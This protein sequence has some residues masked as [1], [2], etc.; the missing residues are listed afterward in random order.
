MTNDVKN[1][2]HAICN[3]DSKLINAYAKVLCLNDTAAKDKN[4]CKSALAILDKKEEQSKITELPSDI[5]GLLH[6]ENLSETFIPERY[7]FR[8]YEKQILEKVINIHKII[9]ELN[10]KKIHFTN[11]LLLYGESGTGKTTLGKYIAYKLEL[12]FM[13]M[14]FSNVVSS[15]LGSTQKNIQKVF[16]FVNNKECVLMLDEI[17]AIGLSRGTEDVGEMSR[18]VISLMQNIDLLSNNVILVGATNRIDMIDKALLRRFTLKSEITRPKDTDERL[19]YLTTFLN[20]VGYEYNKE[21]LRKACEESKTQA[22]LLNELTLAIV[23]KLAN[24]AD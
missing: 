12:P 13:Y 19:K 15:Y 10:K 4:F 14:N 5:K 3:N 11:S 1:L 9:D 16:D 8:E 7:F 2:V 18:V 21:A 17:D 6:C 20:D 24:N 23:Y 22:E